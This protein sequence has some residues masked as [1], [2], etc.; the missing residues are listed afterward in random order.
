MYKT[1]FLYTSFR[2]LSF[3]QEFIA[4][5]L[6][7]TDPTVLKYRNHQIQHKRFIVTNN[8]QGKLRLYGYG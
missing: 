1:S 2:Y 5:I 8:N 6:N 7:P 3:Y 4:T